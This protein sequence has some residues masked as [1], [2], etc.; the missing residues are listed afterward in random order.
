MRRILLALLW[1]S[2]VLVYGQVTDASQTTSTNTT[3][4]N[5]TSPGGIT[6]SAVADRFQDLINS[7]MSRGELVVASG[8][9]NYTVTANSSLTYTQN[10]TVLV[11]FTN[12]NTGSSTLNVN[13]L[14]AKAIKKSVTSN[15]ASGDILANQI[16]LLVYDGTNFQL[17]GSGGSGGGGTWGTITGTLSDQTD[18]QAALDS[19]WSLATGGSLTGSNTIGVAG[20]LLSFDLTDGTYRVRDL[21][22]VGYGEF[23]FSNGAGSGMNFYAGSGTNFVQMQLGLT[24]GRSMF[25]SAA[26]NVIYDLGSGGSNAFSVTGSTSGGFDVNI[27]GPVSLLGEDALN[28]TVGASGAATFTDNA[29]SPQGLEYAADYS[30]TYSNRSLVDK[31]YVTGSFWSLASGGTLT[32]SNTITMG[33]NTI[34][35]TGNR[36]SFTPDATNSGINVGSFAGVPSSTTNGD[37][38]YNS[39]VN[40]YGVKSNG[41]NNYILLGNPATNQIPYASNNINQLTSTTNFTYNTTNGL[42]ASATNNHTLTSSTSSTVLSMN[43]S[44]S[45]SGVL[46]LNSSSIQRNR[47]FWTSTLPTYFESGLGVGAMTTNAAT[48]WTLGSTLLTGTNTHSVTANTRLDVRGFSSGDILRLADNSNNPLFTFSNAGDITLGKD[49]GNIFAQ[50]FT[51]TITWTHSAGESNWEITAGDDVVTKLVD[52]NFGSLN[53]I[54]LSTAGLGDGATL[55]MGFTTGSHVFLDATTN[56]QGLIYADDYSATYVNR[57]LVDKAYVDNAIAGSGS[58]W[59]VTGTTNLTG[60]TTIN[61]STSYDV[62]IGTTTNSRLIIDNTGTTTLGALGAGLY[63]PAGVGAVNSIIVGAVG[64]E[65]SQ[66]GTYDL[67]AGMIVSRTTAS[68]GGMSFIIDMADASSANQFAAFEDTRVTPRGIEYLGDYSAGYTTRSL[69]DKGYVLGAKTYTGTQTMTSPVIVTSLTTSSSTFALLNTTPTTIN[70]GAATT[71]FNIG[72]NSAAQTISIGS[73][74]TGSSTY[75]FGNGATAASNNKVISIGNNGAASSTT[76]VAIAS[77]SVSGV[78]NMNLGNTVATGSLTLNSPTIF[79]TST[80]PTVSSFGTANLLVRRGSGTNLDMV[81]ASGGG[82]TN[83]LRA[84]GTWAAPSGGITNSAANTELMESNGTNAVGSGFYHTSSGNYKFGTTSTSSSYTLT[85]SSSTL[86]GFN[87]RGQSDTGIRG[88]D[89]YLEGGASPLSNTQGGDVWISGGLGNGTGRKGTIA[90]AGYNIEFI[91]AGANYQS[92]AGGVYFKDVTTAP[93][94]N[95]TSGAFFWVDATTHLP[96][97]QVPGGTIY[98][99]SDTG[100]GS[101]LTFQ[102]ILGINALKIF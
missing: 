86:A 66:I 30:A 32:G 82:T 96:K 94:G 91:S 19:K 98:T 73:S 90:L 63:A 29:G 45:S 23:D 55:T 22:T 6:K 75:N 54:S 92:M 9:N 18:L 97:W 99:L 16:F 8:T 88:G 49:A 41:T 74:S 50:G 20:N 12:A 10:F 24:G 34:T 7:K 21:G 37:I 77:S 51:Q 15:L 56:P 61:S 62:T 67:G 38:W 47:M 17:V 68:A 102:Q 53:G 93:S 26:G 71:T 39:T 58:G 84:D 57:S 83:F 48:F 64:G 13:G 60:T 72:A 43:A 70:F 85:M 27:E 44:G 78:V 28:F 52:L 65:S 100:S 4:R 59:A 11:K 69:V 42:A 46:S 1:L 95:P 79:L 81:A 3:I 2:S 40:M 89:I 35:F 76:T 5:I 31:G 33:S 36:V 14:G 87:I 25:V 80:P 101:G